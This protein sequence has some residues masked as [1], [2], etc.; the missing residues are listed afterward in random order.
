MAPKM[1]PGKKPAAI[2]LLG[3]EGQEEARVA[4][5]AFSLEA[6]IEDDGTGVKVI[7]GVD[8]SMVDGE[9][10]EALEEVEEVEDVVAALLEVF[11]SRAQVLFPW[12]V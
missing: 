9:V 11:L 5:L 1:T 2:A 4:P 12:Q 8:E 10:V 7:P 3:N 6:E